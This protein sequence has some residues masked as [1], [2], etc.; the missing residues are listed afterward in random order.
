MQC[1]MLWTVNLTVQPRPLY[2]STCYDFYRYTCIKLIDTIELSMKPNNMLA[3][4]GGGDN[5]HQK[6][7]GFRTNSLAHHAIGL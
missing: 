4:E 3:G 1:I 7:Q 2:V 5:G 6:G